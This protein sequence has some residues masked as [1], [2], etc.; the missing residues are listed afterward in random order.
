MRK[1]TLRRVQILLYVLKEEYIK[2]KKR[3]VLK[4]KTCLAY[5]RSCRAESLQYYRNYAN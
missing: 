2:M 1:Q 5:M 3:V 4:K